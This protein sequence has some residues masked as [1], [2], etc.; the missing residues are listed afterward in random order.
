M[1]NRLEAV[2]DSLHT[3][4]LEVVFR[5]ES[6]AATDTGEGALADIV[7][8]THLAEDSEAVRAVGRCL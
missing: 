3:D 5:V 2:V 4:S 7:S 1:G 8:A 6:G